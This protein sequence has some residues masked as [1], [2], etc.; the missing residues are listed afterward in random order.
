MASGK[1]MFLSKDIELTRPRTVIEVDRDLAGDL[2][3]SMRAL[4]QSL[5]SMLNQDYVN[6]FSLG[7]RSYQVIPQV[8]NADRNDLQKI[9]DYQIATAS[10][11][12]VPL[13]TLVS[14]REEV[15]PSKRVQFQQLNAVTLSGVMLTSLGEALDYL[16]TTGRE[17][18][19]RN[20]RFDYKG[21]SRQ[22]RQEG[23][24]LEITFFLSILVIYLV[25]AAQFES[26]RDPFVILM[27]RAPSASPAPWAFLFLRSRDGEHL[28]PGWA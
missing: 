24:A 18:A 3:I 20:V 5:A 27:S 14:V 17:V 26:W 25:L 12:L 11:E 19:P 16:E 9:Q 8:R 1:F 23:A 13:S 28:H 7:G 22:F 10:G 2:G 15:V 21:E 6:W 4:G